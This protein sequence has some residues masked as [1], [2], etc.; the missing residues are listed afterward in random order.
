[1]ARS[2]IKYSRALVDTRALLDAL[3]DCRERVLAIPVNAQS[4]DPLPKAIG[5][6]L[7][8][9]REIEV[10]LVGNRQSSPEQNGASFIG[11][12]PAQD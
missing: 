9:M 4:F 5:R 10:M 1:M 7:V 6:L 12:L 11:K 3:N 2:S 8:T